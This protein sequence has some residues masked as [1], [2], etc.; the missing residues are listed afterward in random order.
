MIAAQFAR[1]SYYDLEEDAWLFARVT[2]HLNALQWAQERHA[3]I[4]K[5]QAELRAQMQSGR[6]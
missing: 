5:R 2:E 4:E 6:R 1:V 3:E